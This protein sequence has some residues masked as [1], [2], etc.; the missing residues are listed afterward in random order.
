MMSEL[1]FTGWDL[2]LFGSALFV[3]VLL[4]YYRQQYHIIEAELDYYRRESQ[5]LADMMQQRDEEERRAK[6]GSMLPQ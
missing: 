4:G 1:L 6:L 3:G 5:A 2:L